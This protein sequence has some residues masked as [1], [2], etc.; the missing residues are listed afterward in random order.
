MDKDY[1]SIAVDRTIY[2]KCDTPSNYML[3][4]NHQRIE[5]IVEQFNK[6]SDEF[7]V[8]FAQLNEKKAILLETERELEFQNQKFNY[9]KLK[10]AKKSKVITEPLLLKQLKLRLINSKK[11]IIDLLFSLNDLRNKIYMCSMRLESVCN[12]VLDYDDSACCTVRVG[13]HTYTKSSVLEFAESSKN[14]VKNQI[15]G[16]PLNEVPPLTK[17]R[18][19]NKMFIKEQGE[20]VRKTYF[21]LEK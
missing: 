12:N 3:R 18:E 15:L 5:I 9:L 14:A 20:Y 10:N 16:L 8:S 2:G 13:G 7:I 19:L 17:L 11:E 1:L 21:G 4:D 6:F